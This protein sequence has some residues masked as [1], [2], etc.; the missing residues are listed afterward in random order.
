[1]ID[2]LACVAKPDNDQPDRAQ[3]ERG[4][5]IAGVMHAQIHSAER[6]EGHPE[7]GK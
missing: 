3:G 1:M 2:V 4:Q 6:D 7:A 5:N